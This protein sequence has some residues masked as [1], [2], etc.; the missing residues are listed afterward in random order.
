MRIDREKHDRLLREMQ[1]CAQENIA[2]AFSG[3]VDSAL[4]LRIAADCVKETKK[5]L[6]A[7]TF[8]TRLHPAC[9][10][11]AAA[12]AAQEAGVEQVVIRI[13]ELAMEELRSNPVDR[14]YLCKKQLFARLQEFASAQE[15]CMLDGTNADDLQVYRPGLKALAEY[16]VKSPL[17][18][19]GITKA[20]V[21]WLAAEYGI[22]AASRPSTPCM[23]T[24]LP[25]G[26]RLTYELLERIEKAEEWL[27]KLLGEET[28]LRLRVHGEIAR[29]ETDDTGMGILLAQRVAV[30]EKLRQMGFAYI[31]LDLEGFRSGSMDETRQ[32]RH[33][34]DSRL[35][36]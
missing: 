33:D 6:W 30:A 26:T 17:A 13:D 28:N 9:D 7:V 12:R 19:C 34:R 2:L 25:Y 29:I 5:K 31:T 22:S 32:E 18:D 21:R 11:E 10:R 4:L 23:A 27:R 35:K 20:E 24:R 15:A 14:C 3:G 8:E 36:K 16:G 1:A